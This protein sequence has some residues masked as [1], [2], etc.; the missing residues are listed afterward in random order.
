MSLLSKVRPMLYSTIAEAL[1]GLG[2]PPDAAS[3]ILAEL[4]TRGIPC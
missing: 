4:R 3:E 1:A 2:E